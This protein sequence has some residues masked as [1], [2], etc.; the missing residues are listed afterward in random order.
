MP[1]MKRPPEYMSSVAT[2]LASRIGWRSGT[3]TMPVASFSVVV[4]PDAR[5]SATNGSTMSAYTLGMTPSGEP[6]QGESV[7][8]G[9]MGCSGTQSESNPS[10]SIFRATVATSTE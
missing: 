2:S 7:F 8:T 5:A 3:S 6:G 1:K 10:S 9:I 4:T